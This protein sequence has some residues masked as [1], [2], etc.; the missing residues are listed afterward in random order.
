MVLEEIRKDVV[1]KKG[2]THS[3]LVCI[4]LA[5]EDSIVIE[6]KNKDYKAPVLVDVTSLIE[7]Y[8]NED[9]MDDVKT[10]CKSIHEKLKHT[11]KIAS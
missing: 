9:T 7:P 4:A 2:K 6:I 3:K 1:D 10:I 5:E 11:S 8:V